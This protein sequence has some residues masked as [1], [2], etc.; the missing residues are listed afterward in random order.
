M[1]FAPVLALG[2]DAQLLNFRLAGVESFGGR[3]VIRELR[4]MTVVSAKG[5][6]AGVRQIHHT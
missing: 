6:T 4:S 2:F 5:S 1:K 3:G